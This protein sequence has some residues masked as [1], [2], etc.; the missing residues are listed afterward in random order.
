MKNFGRRNVANGKTAET[1]KLPPLKRQ[2]LSQQMQ[3]L[4]QIDID[5]KAPVQQLMK[6]FV[7][8]RQKL[9]HIRRLEEDL[10]F[11]YNVNRKKALPALYEWIKSNGGDIKKTTVAEVPG[12]GMGLIATAPIRKGEPIIT[13]PKKLFMCLDNPAVMQEPYLTEIPFPPTMNVKL[14]F[15]LMVER[16]NPDSFW[17]PY[18]D[19]LPEK[20][21]NFLQ[22][23]VEDME[24][25]KGS[26]AQEYAIIQFKTYV[27]TFAA[28]YSFI[29]QSKHPI[30]ANIRERFSFDLYW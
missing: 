19:T 27:R 21:Q 8:L 20:Y 23:S 26:C 25:L 5:R 9:D 29:H 16:L 22:Y 11:D 14:A 13:I 15:W 12:F 6:E 24:A 1:K 28:M 7:E 2:Q 3:S 17:R 18:I 30:L 10:R 4:L